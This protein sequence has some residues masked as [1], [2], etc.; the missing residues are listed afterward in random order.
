MILE[1]RTL[2]RFEDDLRYCIDSYANGECNLE[3]IMAAADKVACYK[4]N[5]GIRAKRLLHNEREMAFY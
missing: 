5:V 2:E 3:T 1:H 4:A